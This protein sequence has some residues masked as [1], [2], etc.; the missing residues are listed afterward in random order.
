M[1]LATP[2]LESAA[3]AT[4]RACE[5]AG[6][7]VL[8]LRTPAET[9]RAAELLREVWRDSQMPVPANI[10]RTVQHIGGYVFGAY[11]DRGTL[12]AA[13]MGL[14]GNE[15]LHSH[16]TGVVPNGRRRGLGLA[17][18]RHQRWWALDHGL[19]VI[20]WTCDPLVRR[21]LAF[22]LHAL[23]AEVHAY[24]PDHYGN[25]TDG[26]NKGDE[27]DRFELRWHLASP[28]ATAAAEARLPWVSGAR[29]VPL[30]EDIETLR[31]KDPVEA[32]AWRQRVRESVVPALA[33]GAVIAG[34][35]ASGAL[36][37]A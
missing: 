4:D 6:V 31:L 22:N 37:L 16:I 24:L 5:L 14:L 28:R 1:T 3:A 23:G 2:L 35:D 26:V 25:M 7:R 21:N 8:E 11:D 17:L 29:A 34:L 19:P 20:T 27:S 12:V 36:V 15:G 33:G 32:R 13:S 18:K 9:E 10:L 30:P